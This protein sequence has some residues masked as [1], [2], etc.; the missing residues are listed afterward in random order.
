MRVDKFLWCIR[1]F[2]TR[3]LAA[4]N[5]REGRVSI[6]ELAGKPSK[7]IES[8]DVIGVRHSG[9]HRLYKVLS[10]PKS[11]VGAALVSSLALEVT[12]QDELDRIEQVRLM[13]LSQPQH[14]NR[15][16]RPTKR[17]RRNWVKERGEDERH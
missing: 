4:R 15:M 17:D 3:S 16:G 11:R 9:E 2:K 13:A 1:V 10:I 14:P 12:P 8:G 5:A 7:E 6:N